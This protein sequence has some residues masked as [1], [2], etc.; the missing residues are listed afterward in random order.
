MMCM[1][2]C[3]CVC[4]GVN[5]TQGERERER[6]SERAD[7]EGYR[8]IRQIRQKGVNGLN[9]RHTPSAHLPCE[10]KVSCLPP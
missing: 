10:R 3:V 8:A 4:V 7:E 9:V 6:Q 5:E 2:M 1:C